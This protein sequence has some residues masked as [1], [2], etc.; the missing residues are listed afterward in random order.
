MIR[1]GYIYERICSLENIKDAILMASL[2][3]RGAPFVANVLSNI[4]YYAEELRDMLLNHEFV[5]SEYD[6]QEIKDGISGKDRT[7]Y[8]PKFYPDQCVHWALMLQVEDV[9]MR[10]MYRYNCGSIRGRGTIYAKE[11]TENA[12]RMDYKNTKYCFKGD[13]RHF[14]Q[15]CD[16]EVLKEKL[17]RIIKDQ[18]VLDLFGLIIDS[19]PPE[20]GLPLGNYTSQWLGNLMLTSLDHYIKE[21]LKIPYYVRYLDD[22]VLFSPNKK[23]LHKVR[24]LVAAFLHEEHLELKDN[25]Q[26]F[27]VE[28]YDKKTSSYKGRCV[29]FVGYKIGRSYT[30]IRKRIAKRMVININAIANGNYSFEQCARYT[31]YNGYFVH[32]DSHQFYAK[33]VKGRID[34]KRLKKVISDHSKEL[35]Q[36]NKEKAKEYANVIMENQLL[37]YA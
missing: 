22:I 30:R 2:E 23:E 16:H 20:V 13:V 6:R 36:I 34:F 5:P 32:S 35:S 8:K 9:F 27:R 14:Y 7:L 19:V 17:R 1:K 24:A 26:V 18:D 4:D 33:H 11:Y 28:Y 21:V 15:S 29:D 12:M 10:G 31:A 25:W 3:K 37:C